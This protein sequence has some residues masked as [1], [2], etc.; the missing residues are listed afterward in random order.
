MLSTTQKQEIQIGDLFVLLDTEIYVVEKIIYH[1][2][3]TIKECHM[4]CLNAK[5]VN[6]R[7]KLKRI[8]HQPQIKQ[9]LENSGVIE[10]RWK[11]YPVKKI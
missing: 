4:P 5:K 6:G 8:M 3:G 2:D 10:Q 11:H 7:S 1:T 9:I